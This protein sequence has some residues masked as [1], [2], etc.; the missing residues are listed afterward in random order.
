MLHVFGQ[1]LP[2]P[3]FYFKAQVRP[4]D[5]K[6]QGEKQN[7]LK[8]LYK[9]VSLIAL[10]RRD[11]VEQFLAIE[12]EAIINKKKIEVEVIGTS[13]INEYMGYKNIQIKVKQME[14]KMTETKSS[15]F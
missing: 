3:K 6:I 15:L 4:S 10:N 14:M 7:A 5:F 8:L 2:Q 11:L 1:G 9:G 12:Q 13:E